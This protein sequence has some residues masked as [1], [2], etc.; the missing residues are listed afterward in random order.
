MCYTL[1]DN[2]LVAAP[3]QWRG[4]RSEKAVHLIK[5]MKSYNKEM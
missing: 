5:N 1:H 3:S 4:K 2:W